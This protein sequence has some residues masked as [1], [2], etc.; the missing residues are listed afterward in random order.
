MFVLPK[1][2]K[3]LMQRQVLTLQTLTQRCKIGLSLLKVGINFGL[4]R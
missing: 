4:I 2:Q 1:G 3:L